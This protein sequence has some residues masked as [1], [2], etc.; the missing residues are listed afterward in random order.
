[1]PILVYFILLWDKLTG[2]QPLSRSPE[3]QARAD[4]ETK[5]L[6]LYHFRACPYCRKVRRDI[7]LLGL[8]IEERDIKEAPERR[9]E[10]VAGGGKKQVPCLRVS[11]PDG[12]TRWLYESR[13]IAE[14]LRGRFARA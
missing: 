11:E 7:R 10:L 13:D 2:R 5:K 8:H 1:M 3:E 6:A 12:S 9:D 14:Y 4:Q